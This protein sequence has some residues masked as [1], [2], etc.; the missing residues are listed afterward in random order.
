MRIFALAT[1]LIMDSGLL[2]AVIAWPWLI[3]AGVL[4]AMRL[5]PSAV[6]NGRDVDEVANAAVGI[7]M[8]TRLARWLRP[9]HNT[10]KER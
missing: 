10:Q 3:A 8:P 1:V 4:V 2:I 5:S 9:R 6:A 7:G